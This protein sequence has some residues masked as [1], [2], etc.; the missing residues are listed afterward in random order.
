MPMWVWV[1]IGLAT[2]FSLSFVVGLAAGRFFGTVRRRVALQRLDVFE[3]Q[4]WANHAP[5]RATRHRAS[6]Q[7]EAEFSEADSSR[8]TSASG[9]RLRRS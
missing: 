9:R 6:R 2:W 3:T 4:W 5:T 8:I 7:A 1:A